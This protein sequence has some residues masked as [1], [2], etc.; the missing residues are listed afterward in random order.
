M[1]GRELKASFVADNG[2]PPLELRDLNVTM[3]ERPHALSQRDLWRTVTELQRHLLDASL[4]ARASANDAHS[5]QADLLL[6]QSALKAALAEN[7]ALRPLQAERTAAAEQH[8]ALRRHAADLQVQLAAAQQQIA[9]HEHDTMALLRARDAAILQAER[10]R[11]RLSDIERAHRR[12]AAEGQMWQ[13]ERQ[14][15]EAAY[16]MAS[17]HVAAQSAQLA[18]LTARERARFADAD[19]AVTS[20]QAELARL[21]QIE[22]DGTYAPASVHSLSLTRTAAHWAS[23]PPTEPLR[24]PFSSPAN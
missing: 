4:M 11:E 23:L 1:I 16:M 22:L 19:A 20:L 10:A 3:S 15:L 21:R 5:A 17:R 9:A 2:R 14:D 12:L 8:A 24:R 6:T 18:D 13:Q 7:A